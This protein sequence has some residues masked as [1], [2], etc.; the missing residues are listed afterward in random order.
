MASVNLN[1]PEAQKGVKNG[2]EQ[3]IASTRE[4]VE[5]APSVD[6]YENQ[7]EL[8]LVVDLPG[9]TPDGVKID[10]D[11]PELRIRAERV[12]NGDG[13]L[14]YFRAFRV[15][16]RIDPNGIDAELSNG[17]LSVHLRKSAELRPRRVAVKTN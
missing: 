2:A 7:E 14:A 3:E 16:E 15:D 17:V 10:Y 4:A 9:V 5:L 1:R 12:A 8:L 13:A 6:I 11:S